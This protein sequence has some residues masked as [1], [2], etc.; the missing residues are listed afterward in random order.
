M[1]KIN[2]GT[3]LSALMATYP[4][5]LET[6][7]GVRILDVGV[8]Q[9]SPRLDTHIDKYSTVISLPVR[10]AQVI[11][12]TAGDLITNIYRKTRSRMISVLKQEKAEKI[13]F[14]LLSVISRR[15]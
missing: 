8:S 6:M 15:A 7:C 12:C 4:N 13:E 9:C 1:I 14:V 5:N 2:R 10:M 11:Q 3:R